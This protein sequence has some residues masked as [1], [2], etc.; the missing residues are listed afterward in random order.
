MFRRFLLG[1]G[2]ACAA[3]M[4]V[5]GSGVPPAMTSGAAKPACPISMDDAVTLEREQIAH[6]YAQR[7]VAVDITSNLAADLQHSV[8]NYLSFR[9]AAGDGRDRALLFF[10]GNED[11][12][13]AM[14]WRIDDTGEDRLFIV[15]PLAHSPSTVVSLIDEMV[16][17][18]QRAGTGSLRRALPADEAGPM[19]RGVTSLRQPQGRGPEDILPELARLLFPGRIAAHVA[20]LAS[21]SIIPCL[22]IGMVP[23]P[24]LDPDGDGVAFVE[25][26]V[27][28]VE[29]E[30][31]HIYQQRAFGWEGIS[32]PVI[33]GDPEA[34]PYAGWSFPPLPGARR[35]AVAIAE[36]LGRTASLGQ[37][38]TPQRVAASI[39][40]ADYVHIA[41]HGLSSPTDPLDGSFLALAG[42]RMT[43]RQIQELELRGVP[44]VVLS[45]CQTGLGGPLDAGIIGLARGFVLA[46]AAATVAT[47]WDVDDA[48]TEAIMI[49]FV[50][51]LRTMSPGEAM[52]QAQLAARESHPHP[53]YWAGFMLFG[54][55]IVSL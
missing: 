7:G 20:D 15:E 37:E 50:R 9:Q 16:L 3:W 12:L 35:E 33:F 26:T 53:R 18:M 13:C 40:D 43:A 25:T 1:A 17:A 27:V 45:A 32:S 54:S 44:L 49:V 51:N 38:V 34:A 4:A 46:G 28:N 55:R 6:L 48:A 10:I 8:E 41:A 14:F 39:V 2:F 52:R 31:G 19:T 23:F 47:L 11:S 5:L 42:E 36:H 24:A 22:N 21:L 30:L 29:A